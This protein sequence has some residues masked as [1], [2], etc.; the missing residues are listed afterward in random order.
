[1]AD[2][3]Y[4]AKQASFFT[5]SAYYSRGEPEKALPYYKSVVSNWPR[6]T[7]AW[8]AQYMV[9]KCN[10]DLKESGVIDAA[11]ADSEVITAC[12]AVLEKYPDCPAV[13]QANALLA[14]YDK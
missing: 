2:A 13:R 10:I 5:A 9:A 3:R 4:E 1:M 6:Y 7:H 14:R 12:Q 11:L 8:R